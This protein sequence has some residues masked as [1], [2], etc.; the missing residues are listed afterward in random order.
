M[1]DIAQ[2]KKPSKTFVSKWA[3][4]TPPSR[5]EQ[6]QEIEVSTAEPIETNKKKFTKPYYIE[7]ID[8]LG[9]TSK[10][11][12]RVLD[13]PVE[14]I[15]AKIERPE[16]QNLVR[17]NDYQLIAGTYKNTGERGRPIKLYSLETRAAKALVATYESEVGHRY[18]D[19]LFDCENQI[20]EKKPEKKS[21]SEAEA[22]L[23]SN[24][25]VCDLLKVPLHLAQ[26]ESVKLVKK[27]T[28]V[29]FFPLLQL[30]DT[31]RDIKEQEIMYEPTEMGKE[32]GVTAS[33]F[34]K[35]LEAKGLQYKG[36]NEWKATELGAQ[37]STRV[38]WT[39][40]SKTGY[41]L[42]WRKKAILELLGHKL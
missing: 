32:L 6:S 42:K 1:S 36:A 3:D 16:F 31:Q 8:C 11:I 13:V 5:G 12:A 20:T 39:R 4:W 26:I 17:T 37:Y 35:I 18:L 19:F 23:A 40:G 27:E 24:L 25:R 21:R 34:N 38:P 30:S 15:R 33:E 10:D 29:D 28:Q 14:R 2:S 41:N 7:D 9:L 22:L